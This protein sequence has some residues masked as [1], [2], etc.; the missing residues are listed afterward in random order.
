MYDP[1]A[2]Y[3][4]ARERAVAANAPVTRR[5]RKRRHTG[6]LLL[7]PAVI[8]AAASTAAAIGFGGAGH[9]AAAKGP[10]PTATAQVTR[11]TLQD[12]EDVDGNLGY[13]DSV[14]VG[15]RLGGTITALPASGAQVRRGQALFQVD[16]APVV[17]MYGATPLYRRL[18]P[19]TKGPDVKEFEE[20]L[21]AL[22]Y[23]GFTVDDS[24]DANT[25]TAVRAWQNDLG[26]AQSGLVEPGRV[27]FAPAAVR[28]DSDT[29]QVGDPATGAVL[30]YTGTTRE[31]VVQLDVSK[32][33]QVRKDAAATVTLPDGSTVDGRVATIGTVAQRESPGPNVA[34]TS[35]TAVEATVSITDQGKL[36]SLEFAP[37]TV[38]LVVA[39]RENVLTVPVAALLALAEGGYGVQVVEGTGSHV[40]TVHVGLFAGGRVEITGPGIDAGVVVGVP[41]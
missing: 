30:S 35:S 14:K 33:A 10:T 4:P 13:G 27:V 34:A 39:R 37:V 36:G 8:A 20:N 38:H 41:S 12:T 29:A 19:G 32:Q 6:L 25:G 15:T 1:A 28:V 7:V 31:V 22:G 9:G 24:Y 18:A 5:R 23:H 16:G 26:L 3:D 11:M 21:N 40:V 17:L 2:R